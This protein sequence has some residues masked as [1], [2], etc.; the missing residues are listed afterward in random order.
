M[1]K[2]KE[3]V[4]DMGEGGPEPACYKPSIA[5]TNSSVQNGHGPAHMG[6]GKARARY[7]HP[8]LE[9]DQDLVGGEGIKHRAYTPGGPGPRG[10]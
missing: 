6:A 2:S 7:P 10:A 1:A 4:K 9:P 8:P 5:E 3:N